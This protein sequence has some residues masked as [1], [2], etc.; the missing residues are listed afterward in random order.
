MRFRVMGGKEV[1][2]Y[3]DVEAKDRYDALEKA[4]LLESHHWQQIEVD[5]VIEP[6]EVIGEED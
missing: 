4:G 1:A 5:N 2:Y 3:V 6:Y